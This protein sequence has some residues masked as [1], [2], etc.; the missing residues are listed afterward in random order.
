M[1]PAIKDEYGAFNRIQRQ[2]EMEYADG[3]WRLNVKRRDHEK[4]K[5]ALAAIGVFILFCGILRWALP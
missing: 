4:L 1:K 2:R 5:A 3:D